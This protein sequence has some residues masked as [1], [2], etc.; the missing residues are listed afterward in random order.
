MTGVALSSL[1]KFLLYGFIRKD[2]P[3][4]KEGITL[5]AQVMGCNAPSN[6]HQ[7]REGG[8]SPE[9]R[10]K[11]V[12][13]RSGRTATVHRGLLAECRL[14]VHALPALS[15]FL[16]ADSGSAICY[17][18]CA[19]TQAI[20]RCHFEETDPES[21]ELV[22]MKVTP[23]LPSRSTPRVARLI[24]ETPSSAKRSTLTRIQ[25]PPFR[26]FPFLQPASS[27]A[28]TLDGTWKQYAAVPS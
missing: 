13:A 7:A 21:D 10:R 27:C 20:S 12:P 24:S 8:R 2:C 22:L 11:D 9:N 16:L 17:C 1:H 15:V 19:P 26:G 3:R 28:G 18:R 14:I 23:L 4:V 6:K 5:V 25:W